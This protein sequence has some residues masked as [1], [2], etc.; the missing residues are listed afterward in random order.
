MRLAIL[1]VGEQNSGK[2]A[3]IRNLI[4]LYSRKSLTVMRRGFSWLFLNQDFKCLE[5]VTYCVPASPTETGIDLKDR[6]QDWD[7]IPQTLIVAEQL[8][9]NK[10]HNT[11]NFLNTKGYHILR[12]D[13]SNSNGSGIWD[14]FN[15]ETE[16]IILDTRANQIIDDVKVLI[17]TN[18]I[19]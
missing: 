10:Y 14:R 2:T 19:I 15:R 4:N 12:Y 6:F 16:T 8:N 7:N 13:L 9:G 17:K 5:L 1:I 11:L 3:T 18:G